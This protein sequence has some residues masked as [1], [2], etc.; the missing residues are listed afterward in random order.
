MPLVKNNFGLVTIAII[1][2]SLLPLV[3]GVLARSSGGGLS[4][5][6]MSD[7]SRG[8]ALRIEVAA[9]PERMWQALVDP[10]AC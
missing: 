10:G 9:P 7:R 1:L 4:R 8:Y 2:L 5:T 3:V 6:R